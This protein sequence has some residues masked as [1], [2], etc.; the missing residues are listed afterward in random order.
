MTP[1]VASSSSVQRRPVRSCGPL[2]VPAEAP[3]EPTMRA[4][5]GKM[6]AG[7][8]VAAEP[9]VAA[10]ALV[11]AEPVEE[12]GAK[13]ASGAMHRAPADAGPVGAR[14]IAPASLSGSPSP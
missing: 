12:T 11:A 9:V 10:G 4:A 14:C 3:G 1:W 13:A 8:V 2:P 6:E 7:A 5:M